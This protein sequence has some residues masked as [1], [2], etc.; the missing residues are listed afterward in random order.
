MSTCIDELTVDCLVA[1]VGIEI[2]PSFCS[3]SFA[4]EVPVPISRGTE[5]VSLCFFCAIAL[6]VA[7]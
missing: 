5:S 3:S 7:P 1:N 4:K 6:G 2:M